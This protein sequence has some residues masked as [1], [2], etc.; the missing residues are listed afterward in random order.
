MSPKDSQRV[1]VSGNVSKKTVV[2]DIELPPARL[3]EKAPILNPDS[4]SSFKAKL[5]TVSFNEEAF[6][7]SYNEDAVVN[8]SALEHEAAGEPA[9]NYEVR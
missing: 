6:I 1:K 7:Q 3:L 9:S 4:P 8:E 5:R 2:K